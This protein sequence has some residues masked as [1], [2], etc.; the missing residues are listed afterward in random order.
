MRIKGMALAALTIL[1]CGLTGQANASDNRLSM[2]D[3]SMFIDKMEV[4]LNDSDPTVGRLFLERNLV[5]NA[6]YHNN[7]NGTWLGGHQAWLANNGYY[8]SPY[9]YRYPYAQN[10]QHRQASYHSDTKSGLINEFLHKKRAIPNYQKQISILGTKMPAD[11]TSAVVDVRMKE[12]G[13]AYTGAPY[14]YD[15][16]RYGYYPYGPVGAQGVNFEHSD[17]RCYIHLR[18][19]SGDVQMTLLNCNTLVRGPF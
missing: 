10:W 4:A 11:A 12:F 7:V 9:Y 3:V 19:N 15:Y 17:A 6:T 14:G 1:V 13:L 16:Y 18:K 2:N 8:G 5:T